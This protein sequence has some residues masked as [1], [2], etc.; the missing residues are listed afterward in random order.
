MPRPDPVEAICQPSDSVSGDDDRL[1]FIRCVGGRQPKINEI[2]TFSDDG[3]T[4]EV[5]PTARVD[6]GA[7]FGD[8]FFNNYL[9]ENGRRGPMFGRNL[10]N[11]S[12]EWMCVP[13][14]LSTNGPPW[15]AN[16]LAPYAD[17]GRG[18]T[19]TRQYLISGSGGYSDSVHINWNRPYRN[20]PIYHR[21]VFEN[22]RR[23]GRRTCDNLLQ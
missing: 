11:G 18:G 23:T 4:P 6:I 17:W 13:E 7:F 16:I 15:T 10:I 22:T 9:T 20:L 19:S 12:F 2:C 8:F 14:F 3:I 21:R 1:E 5:H